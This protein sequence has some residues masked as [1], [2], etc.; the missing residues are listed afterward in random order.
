MPL[1]DVRWTEGFWANR[2]A[3]NRDQSLPAMWEIMKGTEYKPFLVHFL[4]AAG[5]VEG[6]YHGAQWND[7]DFYKFL[8]GVTATY[9]VTRDPKLLAILDQSIDAIGGRSGRTGISTRRC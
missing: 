8:E 3:V 2:F 1:E 7:G 5:D 4:I 6:D 9:A